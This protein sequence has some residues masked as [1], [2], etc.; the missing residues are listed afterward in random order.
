MKQIIFDVDFLTCALDDEASVLSHE[1]K[2]KPS[3]AE[4]KEGLMKVYDTFVQNKGNFKLLHWLGN[5]KNMGVLGSETREWLD[6]V[7]NETLF[8]K[9]GVQS[10]AVLV[11]TD[12][13]GKYA[14]Q[15]FSKTMS[16][17]YKDKNL[18]MGVFETE[19]EA[20]EWFETIGN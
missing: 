16:E 18:K 19:E 17:K 1:W 8:V 13:F 11:G 6:N 14:M 5:T 7:W 10:H 3:P 2:R 12:I 20:Y 9:A 15:Q 4:F